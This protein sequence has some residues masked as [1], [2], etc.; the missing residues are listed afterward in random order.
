VPEIGIRLALGA[1]PR[2]VHVLIFRQGFTAAAIGLGLGL[3]A[4]A[5]LMHGLRSLL[6][7]LE[8]ASATS[9]WMAAGLVTVIAGMACWIPARRATKVDPVASLRQE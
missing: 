3:S 8:S 5:A 9:V 7:G 1:T 4:T 2:A 6:A